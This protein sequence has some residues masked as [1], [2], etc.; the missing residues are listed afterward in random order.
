[1]TTLDTR[2]LTKTVCLTTDEWTAVLQCVQASY[3]INKQ[4]GH[5]ARA[6]WLSEIDSLIKHQV[7]SDK[8]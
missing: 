8:Y 3:L 1:M 7:H 6:T 5:K 2:T 4:S